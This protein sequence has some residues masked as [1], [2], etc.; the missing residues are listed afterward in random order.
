M[1]TEV[2]KIRNQMMNT[3]KEMNTEAEEK[4]RNQKMNRNGH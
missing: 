3:E 2:E 1:N 4:I